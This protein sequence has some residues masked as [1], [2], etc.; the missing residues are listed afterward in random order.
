MRSPSGAS[1]AVLKAARRG[2]VTLLLTPTLLFEY[3]A[4]CHLAHHRSA[5]GLTTADIDRLIDALVL[6][7]EPVETYF[8]WRPQLRDPADEMVLEAAVNGQADAL[9]TFN[10]RD[11]GRVPARFGIDVLTPSVTLQRIRA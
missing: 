10:Q 4:V 2:R 3:E 7:A 11:Y 1:A 5:S 8:R 6:I 9:V